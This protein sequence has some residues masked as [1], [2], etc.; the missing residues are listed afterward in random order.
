MG[1]CV[2]G[3]VYQFEAKGNNEIV[4][5]LSIKEDCLKYI[6]MLYYIQQFEIKIS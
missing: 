6:S 5:K 1:H 2:L 4:M 3:I